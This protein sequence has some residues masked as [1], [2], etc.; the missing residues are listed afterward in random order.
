MFVYRLI[1]SFMSAIKKHE[2]TVDK[3][4]NYG[5]YDFDK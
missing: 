2:I 3:D 5:N 1:F 4:K